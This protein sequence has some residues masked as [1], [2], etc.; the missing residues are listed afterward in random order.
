MY[1]NVTSYILHNS[2]KFKKKSSSCVAKELLQSILNNC[3][4][5]P[6]DLSKE[7]I[8]CL[9][10]SQESSHE[11]DSNL[12]LGS[13]PVDNNVT[14]AFRIT[15]MFR[16]LRELAQWIP[17]SNLSPSDIS[18]SRRLLELQRELEEFLDN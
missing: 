4:I 16:D 17:S 11:T 1:C 18:L 14:E 7:D 9:I 10:R 13:H 12:R 8:D 6:E 3:L 2:D 15:R 5:D